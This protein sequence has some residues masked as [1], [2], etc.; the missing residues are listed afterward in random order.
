MRRCERERANAVADLARFAP[1]AGGALNLPALGGQEPLAKQ[2]I[3]ALQEVEEKDVQLRGMERTL[4][5]TQV[6]KK[7]NFMTI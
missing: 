6:D 2:L 3:I 5:N 1:S 7:L 4:L